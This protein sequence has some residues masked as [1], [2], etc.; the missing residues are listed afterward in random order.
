[1]PA[2]VSPRPGPAWPA[3]AVDLGGTNVRFATVDGPGAALRAIDTCRGDDFADFDTAFAAYLDKA[4]LQP[5]AIVVAAAGPIEAEDRITVTNRD[6]W[7]ISASRLASRH[8]LDCAVLLNDFEAMVR[9]LPA[10][11]PADAIRVGGEEAPP[12]RTMVL[13]GPG[14][15]LGVATLVRAP[16]GW[17]VVS[18]EGGHVDLAPGTEREDAAFDLIRRDV[19][20]VTAETILSGPGL[21]RL[22]R[23]LAMLDGERPALDEAPAIT[24]AALHQGDARAGEAVAIFCALTG[25]YAGDLALILG[26]R[27]GVYLG[28]GILPRLAGIIPATPLRARFE[29]KAPMEDF[30]RPIPVKLIT[31]AY[32]GLAGAALWL[33]DIQER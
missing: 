2:I 31:A 21:V 16:R 9:V 22:Y 20:R 3:V 26:A 12:D 33:A 13:M 6:H 8:D 18:G 28:G 10:L 25:A 30:V 17:L 32:P 11:Q 27:G 7:V 14:T 5:R 24:A 1:M 15:G 4:G 29:A 19:G 23:T